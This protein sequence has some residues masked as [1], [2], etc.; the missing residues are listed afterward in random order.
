MTRHS[1]LKPSLIEFL[2]IVLGCRSGMSTAELAAQAGVES[3]VLARQIKKLIAEGYI[4]V[5]NTHARTAAPALK[6]IPGPTALAIAQLVRRLFPFAAIAQ[7]ILEAL[8]H[9]TG[10]SVVL[11][12]YEPKDRMAICVA[13]CESPDPLQYELEVGELKSLHAGASGKA[14]LAMLPVDEQ[15]AILAL[16]L[17]AVTCRTQTDSAVLRAELK[18]I[19]ELGYSVTHGQRI[20]GA[21]G[22]AAYLITPLGI[23]ASLVITLPEHRN[24]AV[25]QEALLEAL[26]TSAR[27]LESA[28]AGDSITNAL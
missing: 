2:T 8:M 11:N 22:H 17:T 21:V 16:P 12:V 20:P 4:S 7:P 19:R 13:V 3:T 23:P 6:Y 25:N 26:V 28:F 24:Q 10:E 27:R 9:L 18:Q 14:I 5:A 15:E 1:A